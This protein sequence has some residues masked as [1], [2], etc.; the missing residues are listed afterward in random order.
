M[1]KTYTVKK[2]DRLSS[3][4]WAHHLTLDDLLRANP[5]IENPNVIEVGLVLVI[6]EVVVQMR[7]DGT[8]LELNDK[9]TG[10]RLARYRARSGLP[11]GSPAIPYVAEKHGLQLDPKTDYT[12]PKYQKKA[13]AGPIPE[14]WYYLPLTAT[15]SYD[16]TG[17]R[18]GRGWGVGAWLLKETWY[19]RLGGRDGFFLHHDG[20]SPGT[21]GCIG[22]LQGGDLRAVRERLRLA[23]A[24]GQREV[25]I[26]VA[27]R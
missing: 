7:F 17:A 2:G 10:H 3:I 20:G 4:A 27:Y 26:H 16:K 1:A 23:F 9:K 8:W 19:N 6:P 22:L 13:F 14:A 24:R 11:A 12:D 5:E 18:H 15:M 25:A 21:S